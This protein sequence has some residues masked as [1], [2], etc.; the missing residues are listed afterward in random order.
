MNKKYFFYVISLFILLIGLNFVSAAA[1][2]NSV[3][4]N[5]TDNF[6]SNYAGNNIVNIIVNASGIDSSGIVVANFS[7]FA[8]QGI[9][10][11][12]GAV[13]DTIILTNDTYGGEIYN[14]SCDVGAEATVANFNGS[15]VMIVAANSTW[16]VSFSVG[17]TVILYSMGTPQYLGPAFTRFGDSTTNFTKV[18]DFAH[19]NFITSI[20]INF[21]SLTGGTYN[22]TISGDFNDAML[23][24]LTSVNLSDSAQA[25]QL[26]QLSNAINVSIAQ[27]KS[28]G[29]SRIY[30]NS[31]A[32]SA[33]N[34]AGNVTLYNLP[35]T[36][37]P[38]VLNDSGTALS[39]GVYWYS[40]GYSSANG[41]NTGNLTFSVTG[42]SGYNITD[43]VNPLVT[44]NSPPATS[45]ATITSYNI[46]VNGTGTEPSFISI[47]LNGTNYTY[48]G[49][50]GAGIANCTNISSSREIFNCFSAIPPLTDGTYTLSVT[51]FDYGGTSGNSN[52]TSINV[53]VDSTA[54]VITVYSPANNSVY[55]TNQS[56]LVYFS[57]S[58]LTS[59]K[60][61]YNYNGTTNTSAS[62]SNPLSANINYTITGLKNITLYANDSFGA[63]RTL[64]I[65][66]NVTDLPASSFIA[67]DTSY[68]V[69]SSITTIVVPFNSTLQTITLTNTTQIV[70]FD[71]SQS[72]SN[73][74][75]TV[76]SNN[77]TLVTQ[78]T[79]NYTAV[80]P[81]GINITGS[82]WDGKLN[83]PTI[84]SSSFTAP[85]GTTNIVVDMGSSTELNFSSPVKI[86]IG[87]MAG[88]SAAWSRGSL[89]LTPISTVCNSG[90]STNSTAPTNIDATTTKE[91]KINDGSD[92]VIWTYHFT[93]FAAYTPATTTPPTDGGSPSGGG[94]PP[95]ETRYSGG[96]LTESGIIY[97][98]KSGEI[99]D[100]TISSAAHSLTVLSINQ[101]SASIK[102]QSSPVTATI[103]KGETKNFD[104]DV[105]GEYDTSVYL[106]D[107]FV[108]GSMYTGKFVVKFIGT[109]AQQNLTTVPSTCGNGAVDSNETCSNCAADVKCADGEKCE[110]S[111]CV[112]TTAAE[113]VVKT[114]I[115][116][117][118]WLGGIVAG[119]VIV[120]AVFVIVKNYTKK[121]LLKKHHYIHHH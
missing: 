61:W 50:T 67:N 84:N 53:T 14:G 105:N 75:V 54:P 118:Y 55:Y 101:L 35:F 40:N 1:V 99:L 76:G 3:N 36:S 120:A 100:F 57:A 87:G 82:N 102:M 37:K 59:M 63:L 112:P 106:Q 19:V 90:N 44:I 51:A 77:F 12:C 73:G 109:A 95:S 47:T 111:S 69:S 10:I 104:L 58:D 65:R 88:K 96:A 108:S 85:S 72:L 34:T 6:Y 41:V 70:S 116:T 25:Q 23:M 30:V 46:T 2:I 21:T 49:T 4:L 91:C 97:D 113:E 114:A 115:T 29:S 79:Y 27:P 121:R 89:T 78:G 24:N 5:D 71:L 11:D 31:T 13:S 83:L 8:S 45:N 17:P 117:L 38:V 16:N 103:N 7:S 22:G 86:I 42:F 26:S 92:L 56:F 43:N 66:I 68:N 93:S 107:I 20:Q 33:L 98:L 15:S 81:A 94:A 62:S 80:I 52:T 18:L 110:N 60:L 9:T 48:N 39:S 28:Y 64:L 119:L 74:V 32:F